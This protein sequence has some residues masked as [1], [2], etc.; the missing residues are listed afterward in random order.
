MIR[1]TNDPGPRRVNL[2]FLLETLIAISAMPLTST[3]QSSP[4][5]I[6]PPPTDTIVVTGARLSGGRRHIGE[7]GIT[8]TGRQWNASSRTCDGFLPPGLTIKQP[9]GTTL[10]WYRVTSNW[11]VHDISLFRSS[12]N[13]ALDTA[14]LACAYGSYTRPAVVAGKVS[15]VVAIGAVNWAHF[16]TPE[17][18]PGPDGTGQNCFRQY[19]P[20]NAVRE[21]EQGS[22]IIG[23]RVAVDG[24]VTDAT[25]VSSSGT[26]SL[27]EASLKC[28]AGLRYFP[29]YQNNQ[30]IELDKSI[31]IVWQL[32]N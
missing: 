26:G 19:Y 2:V 16:A 21:Q 25:V 14:A 27:D 1:Q 17:F 12:G 29:A 11:M 23:Y 32:M 28:V 8:P 5:T 20:P 18:E 22:A 6:W 15:D 9:A 4:G 30:P 3:A 13:S 24:S 10:F 31:R 7:Y